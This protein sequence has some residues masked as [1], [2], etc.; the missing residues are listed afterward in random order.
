MLQ[1]VVKLPFAN[2][3]RLAAAAQQA[4]PDEQELSADDAVLSLTRF[5]TSLACAGNMLHSLAH[6]FT[7][8]PGLCL[9][10]ITQPAIHCSYWRSTTDCLQPHAVLVWHVSSTKHC[11]LH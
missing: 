6:S 4:D 11:R 8:K 5:L 10:L 1:A 3:K 9:K 2:V 7:Y